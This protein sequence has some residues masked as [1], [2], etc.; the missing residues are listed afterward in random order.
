MSRASVST[1]VLGALLMGAVP[2]TAADPKPDRAAVIAR[3]RVWAPTNV[4][5]KDIRRGPD[6][7]GGFQPGETIRCE[8]VERKLSGHSPKFACRTR[9]NQE[10]KVKYGG[11]NGEV[12]GEVAATRLLWALGFGADTM[13]PVK[14]MCH[15]C[16]KSVIG[17][18]QADGDLLIDPAAIE[19][20]HPGAELAG[21]VEGWAWNELDMVSESA[22]GAPRAQRDALKL[23][24]VFLQ[25]TDNKPQ[26]QRLLCLDASAKTKTCARP[27]MMIN[28]L[29]L[30]FGRANLTNANLAGSVNLQDW[31]RTPVWKDERGCVGNLPKSFTGTLENPQISEQGRQFLAGLLV[32]LSDAQLRDLFDVARFQL[33]PRSPA[34]G[35]SGFPSTQEWVDAFKLKRSQIVERRCDERP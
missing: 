24:A 3:A 32:Q 10:L 11:T 7:R 29:G 27:F 8:Y 12:Y 13:S 33:R 22:G 31:S 16:P 2:Q 28:D 23:L 9:E 34:S 21:D 5:T 1:A 26:Q 14:V 35:P 15:G 20:K 30:T 25:H 4:A 17:V 19:R 6:E 18:E